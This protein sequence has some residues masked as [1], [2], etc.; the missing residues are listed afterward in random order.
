MTA[1]DDLLADLAGEI[2]GLA[3]PAASALFIGCCQALRPHYDR[4]AAHR[5]TSAADV[6]DDALA[7]ARTFA[8][9]GGVPMGADALLARVEEA[10]PEGDSPDA[11]S[12][13]F[14][15][16]CWIC[17]D[18]A[19]RTAI[20]DG[21]PPGYAVEYALDPMMI[22]AT[23]RLFGVSQ[24]GSGPDEDAGV[25]AVLAEPDVQAA[26]DACRTAIAHLAAHPAPTDDD[27][28]TVAQQLT[29]LSPP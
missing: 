25:R 5:G 1:F 3:V 11:Y 29:A 28:A 27:L 17:G 2:D 24:L 21:G 12:S 6:L 26:V 13:T 22:T 4:W 15:Q 8:T 9:G 19:L 18:V 14:A 7:A 20:G 23:E 10:T 16:S